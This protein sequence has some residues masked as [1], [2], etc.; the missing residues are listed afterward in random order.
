MA[1]TWNKKRKRYLVQ[2]RLNGHHRQRS[3]ILKEDADAYERKLLIKKDKHL[4]HGAND[5]LTF[6]DITDVYEADV[7]S[8]DSTIDSK[9]DQ[10][11][12]LKV[13]R[14]IIGIFNANEITRN[15][16]ILLRD[17]LLKRENKG[18]KISKARVNRYI[19][20]VSSVFRHALE[21]DFVTVNPCRG[22]KKFPEV[23][24]KA[25]F[26]SVEEYSRLLDASSEWLK[27]I[28]IVAVGTGM[29]L[30]EIIELEWA[31]IDFDKMKIWIEK[32]K[33]DKTAGQKIVY[34]PF[35]VKEALLKL[36]E[37]A[38]FNLV[39]PRKDG[40]MTRITKVRSQF[41]RACEKAELTGISFHTLRHTSASWLMMQTKDPA[42]VKEQLGHSSLLV[43][44]RYTH[45]LEKHRQEGIRGIDD[46]LKKAA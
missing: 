34:F 2:V 36:K 39:F 41:E 17:K 6:N 13:V 1:V 20:T 45:L 32:H 10:L 29:R 24:N 9:P 46:F 7:L 11:R 22:I 26:L 23:A 35:T 30:G 33:A 37:K 4:I 25:R 8:D 15:R 16:I 14:G 27:P 28:V 31:R 38:T 42:L 3:F 21:R 43:T 12:M 19:S 40:G 18:K 44:Q 5:S